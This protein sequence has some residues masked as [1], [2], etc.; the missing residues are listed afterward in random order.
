MN[1]LFF[2]NKNRMLLKYQL[3]IG[4]YEVWVREVISDDKSCLLYLKIFISPK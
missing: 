4:N 2:L 3:N 1:K